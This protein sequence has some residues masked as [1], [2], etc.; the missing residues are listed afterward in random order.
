MDLT[1]FA[2]KGADFSVSAAP[3]TQV[4]QSPWSG[5]AGQIAYAALLFLHGQ[6]R[7]YDIIITEPSTLGIL[8]F[9][10]K[11]LGGCRWVVDVWDI[12]IRSILV[13]GR[14]VSLRCSLTRK[15]LR[16]LYRWADLFIV[17]ILPDFEL[18][19]FMI[20]QE[21]ML[22][23][24]NAIWFDVDRQTNVFSPKGKE[25]ELFCMRSFYTPHMGLDTLAEA[26]LI[27]RKHVPEIS[28]TIIGSVR[29]N[30][31]HQ[32]APLRGMTTVRFL[33]FVEHSELTRLIGEASV[34]I[35]PFHDVPDLAQT[36]PIKVLEYMAQGKPVVASNIAGM[37]C[38]IKDGHNGLLYRAD[39]PVDLANKI[40]LLYE[41]EQLRTNL[42][43][44]ASK[45]DDDFDCRVKNARIIKV[46]QLIAKSDV[47]RR[48][49][50]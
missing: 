21:R 48:P 46:L 37:S 42:G 1:V 12:P 9:L 27:L 23:L 28:L 4:I 40:I 6:A 32:V 3:G 8:G 17:S 19:E 18:R 5:K 20:P 7:R 26:M 10:G 35:V 2:R 29:A 49:G 43:R 16:I 13:P 50:F 41:N 14:I 25:F 11:L 22:L 34:C 24:K 45:M 30:I 47:A 33:D 38:L 36:Y 15:I 31:E 39:D 44:N